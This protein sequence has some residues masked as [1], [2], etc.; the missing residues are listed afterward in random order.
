MRCTIARRAGPSRT[1][2]NGTRRCAGP[3]GAGQPLWKAHGCLTDAC[4]SLRVITLTAWPPPPSAAA[5]VSVTSAGRPKSCLKNLCTAV[6]A[7]LSA[8]SENVTLSG[9]PAAAAA[10][11]L[12]SSAAGLDA[13]GLSGGPAALRS[14][15]IMRYLRARGA[16]WCLRA[17]TWRAERNCAARL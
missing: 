14:A 9:P 4:R 12:V 15:Y 2:R 5:T 6:R 7:A 17:T 16:Y 1:V 13:S 3:M 8:R 11:A 10:A